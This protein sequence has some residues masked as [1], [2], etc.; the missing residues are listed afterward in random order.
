MLKSETDNVP[1]VP[2]GQRSGITKCKTFK[3]R[4]IS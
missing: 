4:N 3:I 2:G 1:M